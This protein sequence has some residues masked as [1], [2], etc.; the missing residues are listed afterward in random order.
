MKT[1]LEPLLKVG[2]RMRGTVWFEPATR[3]TPALA[4]ADGLCRRRAGLFVS[5]VLVILSFPSSAKAN[6][7][8][9]E[10]LAD[11]GTLSQLNSAVA[12]PNGNAVAENACVP[13]SVANGLTY[14]DDIYPG[15]VPGLINSYSTVNTLITD[16]GTTANGTAFPS[17]VAGLATYIGPTGQNV[18]PP[19]Q[20]V[21][22]QI[23]SINGPWGT[24][25]GYNIQN[26]TIPTAMQMYNWLNASD[27]VEL[28]VNWSGGGAHSV[29]LYGIDI[30]IANG[31]PTGNGTLSF[32]DPYGGTLAGDGDTS[33]TIATATS[34]TVGGEIYING[35]YT[36][37]A[38][39]NGNDP[40]NLA[41]SSTGY[42]VTDLA[43]AVPE[44]SSTCIAGALLLLPF[45]ASALRFLRRRQVV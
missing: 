40:D 1:Q 9:T 38:A 24:V 37:G 21:G 20:I 31:N 17:E 41:A 14:L 13:T 32:I 6:L 33:V 3:I 4:R 43:E 28:W 15:G 30:G 22:G 2:G 39:N 19:V 42:I 5:A 23:S 7:I 26:N 11:F 25:N 45:G 29:T 16:M 34:S 27:A 18:S 44:P 12:G 35:G 36:G 8:S 10:T